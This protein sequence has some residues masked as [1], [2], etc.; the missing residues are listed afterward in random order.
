[1]TTD[2]PAT[3]RVDYGTTADPLDGSATVAGL[4]T[5]HVVSFGGLTAGT[6]YHYRVTSIDVRANNAVSPPPPGSASFTTPPTPCAVDDS[7]A[8]FAQGSHVNTVA[9]DA[10]GGEVMLA[11]PARADFTVVPPSGE[12][13]GFPWDAGGTAAVAGGQLALDGERFVSEPLPGFG[14]GSAVEFVATFRAAPFQAVGFSAGGDAPPNTIFGALP[15][16][17]F[18]TASDGGVL[19]TRCWDGATLL[20]YVVPGAWLGTPHRYRIEWRS[21]SIRFFVDGALV[22]AERV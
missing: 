6:L 19:R 13:Q 3:S 1:W 18:G 14:A 12:W 17:V 5:L 15:W 22:R 16:A 21:S 8:Q 9:T 2:E 7:V 4:A 11:M 10:E 20:D